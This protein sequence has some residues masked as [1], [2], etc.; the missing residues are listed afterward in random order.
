[1]ADSKTRAGNIQWEPGT[2]FSA[3]KQGSAIKKFDEM[4]KVYQRAQE[5]T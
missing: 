5:P 1:M 3:R 4:M 2:Y